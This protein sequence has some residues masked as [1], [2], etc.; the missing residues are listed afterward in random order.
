MAHG[1]VQEGFHWELPKGGDP[2]AVMKRKKERHH[3]VVGCERRGGGE[4]TQ[5]QAQ[6][7]PPRGRGWRIPGIQKR[8]PNPVNKGACIFFLTKDYCI[9]R[10][11]KVSPPAMVFWPRGWVHH[12]PGRSG[13]LFIVLSSPGEPVFI[14]RKATRTLASLGIYAVC[15]GVTQPVAFVLKEVF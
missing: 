15:G 1:K 3:Q 14:N 5:R 10:V 13:L 9:V 4:T 8:H 11:L 7:E 6:V 2:R 12:P